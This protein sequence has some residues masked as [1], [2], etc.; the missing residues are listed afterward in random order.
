MMSAVASIRKKYIKVAF[1][2]NRQDARKN[3]I[4]LKSRYELEL[5]REFG[6]GITF[7]ENRG[8]TS[9]IYISKKSDIEDR[10]LWKEQYKWFKDNLE[11]FEE[12]FRT[13]IKHL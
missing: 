8:I 12:Y 13:R 4:N 6:S 2:F 5:I 11:K 1:Y 9:A 10:S 3:F 7:Q